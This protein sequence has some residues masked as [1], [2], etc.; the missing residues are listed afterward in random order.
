MCPPP[1]WHLSE[2]HRM[3]GLD[4]RMS[5]CHRPTYTVRDP[6]RMLLQHFKVAIC[7]LTYITCIPTSNY[8]FFHRVRCSVFCAVPADFRAKR[9]CSN[10][11]SHLYLHW[12][13]CYYHLLDNKQPHSDW[14]QCSSYHFSDTDWSRESHLQPHTGS[15]WETSGRVSVYCVQQQAIII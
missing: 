13:S 4:D 6:S 14:G 10:I 7:M 9:Y 5:H 11:H 15:N 12:W 1:T 8:N 3:D 2:M